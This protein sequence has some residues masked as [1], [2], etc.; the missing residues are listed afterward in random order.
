MF[1]CNIRHIMIDNEINSVTELTKRTVISRDTVN[2]LFKND[3][4]KTIKLEN[5][6]HVCNALHC[7]LSDL[8]EY[9]PDDIDN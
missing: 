9:I 8:I 3:D 1:K 4:I 7:K 5:L 2:K 6:M